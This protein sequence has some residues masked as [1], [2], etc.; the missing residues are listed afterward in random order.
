MLR[1][2]LLIS[3]ILNFANCIP[4]LTG[5]CGLNA[6]IGNQISNGNI[7]YSDYPNP[8][9]ND[10]LDNRI[11]D[12]DEYQHSGDGIDP[13]DHFQTTNIEHINLGIQITQPQP[14][15]NV[16]L[17]IQ[18]PKVKP[19]NHVKPKPS[20]PIRPKKPNHGKGPNHGHVKPTKKP[21][22]QPRKPDPGQKPSVPCTNANNCIAGT[23]AKPT[24]NSKGNTQSNGHMKPTKKPP[25]ITRKPNIKITTKKPHVK[26]TNNGNCDSGNNEQP[27]QATTA[28]AENTGTII[29]PPVKCTSNC[30][31]GTNVEP[32]DNSKGN[33]QSKGHV[34]PTKRPPKI[35]K[36]PNIKST[37]KK[38]HV[39]CTNNGNCDSGNNEQP[40]Q[41]TTATPENTGTIISPPVKCTSNCATGTNVEPTDNSKGNTQSKGH[42]KPTK[43]PPKITKKPNIKSTTKKPHV[44]CTNNGKCDSGNNEQPNQA[45]T[46]TPENTGAIINPPVKC[47]N[48]GKCDSGNNVQPNQATTPKNSGTIKNNNKCLSKKVCTITQDDEGKQIENCTYYKDCNETQNPKGNNKAKPKKSVNFDKVFDNLAKKVI[49]FDK[50]ILLHC[51]KY[52]N[53]VNEFYG[54]DKYTLEYKLPMGYK[55]EDFDVK[56]KHRVIYV[57]ANNQQLGN[58]N[59]IRLVSDLLN[60]EQTDWELQGDKLKINIPYK[61]QLEQQSKIICSNA[62]NN[63][64]IPILPLDDQVFVYR[65]R[66]P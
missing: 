56:A 24:E 17:P 9:V 51:T 38:P 41:A 62:I 4:C 49:A 35:T 34:K 6:N 2:I 31:T 1:V 5:D 7:D 40:N 61:T 27:N 21:P 22:K 42:V 12:Q 33:N 20:P 8:S 60:I 63:N 50:S 3:I 43:R 58:F 23:N 26:C 47:T 45:T 14:E 64:T 48:N 37:T 25:K 30:A 28:T 13:D 18:P 44:K 65:M 32:T 55:T 54:K 46:A 29:S 53:D 15:Y 10:V 66:K 57:K 11:E 59:D 19:P 52:P 39:K 16:Y 36:K